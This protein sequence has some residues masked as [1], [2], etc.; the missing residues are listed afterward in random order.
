MKQNLPRK[1][2]RQF[3]PSTLGYEVMID[4]TTWRDKSVVNGEMD[5]KFVWEESANAPD[6]LLLLG[7]G[8]SNVGLHFVA[9]RVNCFK[10]A[11]IASEA[12]QSPQ[13]TST[14]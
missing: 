3:F 5:R 11:P 7:L 14:V 12:L 2:L 4:D 1:K 9:Q 8:P 6:S 13:L 10:A